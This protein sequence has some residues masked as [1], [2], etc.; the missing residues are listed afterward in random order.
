MKKADKMSEYAGT[1][2]DIKG[3][4]NRNPGGIMSGK[5]CGSCLA[6]AEIPEPGS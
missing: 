6:H 2:R 1:N 4:T 3:L 5:K